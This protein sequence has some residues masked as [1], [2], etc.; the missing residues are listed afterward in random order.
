MNEFLNHIQAKYN[1]YKILENGDIEISFIIE[2]DGL[3]VFKQG[4]QAIKEYIKQGKDKLSLTVSKF[5]KKRSL[6]AN[7]YAWCLMSQLAAVLK[8][9]KEEVYQNYIT[10]IGCFEPLPIKNERVE[11]FR[12]IW[13]AKG[14]GWVLEVID[15]SKLPGYKLCHAHY[16]SSTYNTEQMSRLIEMIVIDCKEQNIETMTPLE[17]QKLKEAWNERKS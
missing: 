4:V 9:S 15:N 13:Q 10:E 5:Y 7:A 16:G 14:T 3:Y 8:I 2:K 6:D 12:E 17:L 1:G 11:N